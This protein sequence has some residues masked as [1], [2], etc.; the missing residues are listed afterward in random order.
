MSVLAVVLVEAC[1]QDQ[2]EMGEHLW[3]WVE[4]ASPYLTYEF[5]FLEEPTIQKKLL[6]EKRGKTEAQKLA[7]PT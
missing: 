5:S 6:F 7:E 2:K 3:D 4:E 1:R